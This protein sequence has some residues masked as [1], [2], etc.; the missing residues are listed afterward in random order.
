[1]IL[2]WVVYLSGHLTSILLTCKLCKVLS[3][4]KTISA[5]QSQ[6]DTAN[7]WQS[8]NGGDCR[9]TTCGTTGCRPGEVSLT[10]SFICLFINRVTLGCFFTDQVVSKQLRPLA[11]RIRRIKDYANF[12][13]T[14][15]IFKSLWPRFNVTEMATKASSAVHFRPLLIQRPAHGKVLFPFAMNSASLS[16]LSWSSASEAMAISVVMTGC[17][18][19]VMF[20]THQREL[21]AHGTIAK[22]LVTAMKIS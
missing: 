17:F 15:L 20:R 3:I 6:A 11:S 19:A 9:G 18:T 14:N 16:K 5:L 22:A 10:V 8:V 21:T 1:M 4:Q 13:C 12:R 2:V 7:N